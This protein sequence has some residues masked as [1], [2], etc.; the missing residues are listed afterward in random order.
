MQLWQFNEGRYHFPIHACIIPGIDY[1]FGF[2]KTYELNAKA[3]D[4]L[5]LVFV[6]TQYVFFSFNE[7]D[8]I[9]W[10]AVVIKILDVIVG[11]LT[12]STEY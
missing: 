3:G 4:L 6:K 2:Y 7:L 5:P 12:A 8:V 11:N 1:Y 10:Q 9:I